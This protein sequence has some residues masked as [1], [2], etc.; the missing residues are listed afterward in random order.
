MTAKNRFPTPT[1][2]DF[3]KQEALPPARAM[4]QMCLHC[5]GNS[6]KSVRECE[7]SDCPLWP[8]RH[9]QGIEDVQGRRKRR[10]RPMSDD[11]RKAIGAKPKEARR[12]KK[13]NGT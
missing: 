4:R 7:A 13:T 5:T 8:Y 12:S 6:T 9:G 2:Y 3:R 10:S 1:G 11:E